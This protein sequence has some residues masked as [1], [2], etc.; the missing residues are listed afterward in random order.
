MGSVARIDVEKAEAEIALFIQKLSEESVTTVTPYNPSVMTQGV[1][2]K[3]S[4]VD[5]ITHNITQNHVNVT[6]YNFDANLM[7]WRSK[8]ERCKF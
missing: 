8:V 4:T 2:L 3:Q 1:L 6:P 5:Q 7:L